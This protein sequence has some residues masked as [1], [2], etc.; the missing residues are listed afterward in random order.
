MDN[1]GKPWREIIPLFKDELRRCQFPI[2]NISCL[3]A[4]L[5][6]LESY[7]Y[8]QGAECYFFELGQRFLSLFYPMT[9]QFK[10][11]RDVDSQTRNAYWAI[12]LLNDLFLHGYFTTTKNMRVLPLKDEDELLLIKFQKY[13]L[14]NGF[15]ETTAKKVTISMRS[16]LTYLNSHSV[17]VSD[18]SDKDIIGF[19]SAYI[20]KSKPY[21]N[22]IILALKRFSDFLFANGLTENKVSSFIPPLNKMVSP[23]VP[24]VWSNDEITKMLESV[25]RG[26]PLGKRDYAILMIAIKLGLR[27]SDIKNLQLSDI[28]WERKCINITQRKTQKLLSL[29]FTNDVGWAIIDYLKNARP[30]SDFN[31]VFLTHA[32]PIKPFSATTS[33]YGMI[34]RYRNIAGIDLHE[35]SRRGMHS[36][37][38]TFATNLLRHKIPLETIAEMLGHVGMSSVDVYLT[39]ETQELRT[40][41]LDP[42]EVFHNGQ[43][44]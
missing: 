10:T 13:Q 41:A 8:S 37:R 33:L 27:C 42:E 43:N 4:K 34:S 1:N 25:D 7:G 11:W 3:T 36:I 5:S 9:G 18:I 44:K 40:I 29:P 19:L 39:V 28:D 15:A 24:N 35:T 16:F 38:H 14:E 31:H 12:G 26:S 21:I 30:K 32:A 6:E 20:D 22:T 2:S 23:R 17:N